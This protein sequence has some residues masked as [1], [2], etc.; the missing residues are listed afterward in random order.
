MRRAAANI[1]HRAVIAWPSMGGY[2]MPDHQMRDKPGAS[3]PRIT[4]IMD[5]AL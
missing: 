4:R 3:V 5:A 2:R 1:K